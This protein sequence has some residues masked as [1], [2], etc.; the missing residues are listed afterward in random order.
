MLPRSVRS[1]TENG[2]RVTASGSVISI[3]AQSTTFFRVIPRA[4][5]CPGQG[6]I[7]E[8]VSGLGVSWQC[9]LSGIS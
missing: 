8:V 9:K 4:V 3:G 2:A 1:Q 5:S 7:L 6:S